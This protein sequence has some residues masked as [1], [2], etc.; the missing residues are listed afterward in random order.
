M[1]PITFTIPASK[2]GLGRCKKKIKNKIF[3]S[4]VTLGFVTVCLV[5]LMGLFYLAQANQTAAKGY[6]I[7]NCEEKIEELRAMNQKLKVEAAELQ[8][9]NRLQEAKEK[10]NLV[11]TSKVSY[12]RGGDR[13]FVKR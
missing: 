2:K 5:C 12:R 8:S 11:E 10:F 3:I 4:K 7:R 6:Q 13:E 1:S 9:V